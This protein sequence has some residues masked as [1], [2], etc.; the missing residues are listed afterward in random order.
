MSP[1]LDPAE[2]A[3]HRRRNAL[4]S[5]LI[6]GGIGALTVL[7]SVL[8]WSWAGIF[9]AIASIA[10]LVGFAPRIAPETVMRYY[11]GQYVDPRRGGQL[12]RLV[13]I[14]AE[15][16]ELPAQPKLFVVPSATLNAFATGT[17]EGAAIAVTE[18]LLRKLS[19]REI[20]GVLAHEM[21]HIRNNDLVVMGLADAMTRFTQ[22]LAYVAVLLAIMNVPAMLLGREGFPWLAVLLLYTAPTLSSLLQLALSRA[23]EY[24]ADREAAQLTGDPVGLASALR[25]LERYQGRFWEDLMLPVPGRRIPQPS[26]LRSHPETSDRIRRLLELGATEP[27]RRIVMPEEPMFTLVGL[28]PGEMAP[29]YRW[30]GVW[31]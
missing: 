16:A 29:R 11:R 21:S 18:G 14:L 6:V 27:G 17:R 4:H 23:R 28:G 15:R 13:T 19:L 12:A 10:F 25:S 1:F 5:M 7:S 2:F 8:L 24:D 9:V 26:L 20:A 3:E 31:Y 22:V 30:P